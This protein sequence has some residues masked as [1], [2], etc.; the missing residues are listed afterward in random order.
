MLRLS[1]REHGGHNFEREFESQGH[2]E[3]FLKR[4]RGDGGYWVGAAG[5][6]F[7]VPWHRVDLV[8]LAERAGGPE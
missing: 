8:R 5:G 3:A 4:V 7:F 2:A 1:I 6:S